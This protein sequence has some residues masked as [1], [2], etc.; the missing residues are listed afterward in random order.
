MV[1]DLCLVCKLVIISCWDFLHTNALHVHN[2][3]ILQW[4][5]GNRVVSKRQYLECC[6]TKFLYRPSL[7]GEVDIIYSSNWLEG[8]TIIQAINLSIYPFITRLALNRSTCLSGLTCLWWGVT[9][10]DD[11]EFHQRCV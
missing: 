3:Y 6:N 1:P 2:S 4:N 8:I 7:R 9:I 11:I 5:Q 10:D